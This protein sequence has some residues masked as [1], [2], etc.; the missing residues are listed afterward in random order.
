MPSKSLNHLSEKDLVNLIAYLKT[1]PAIDNTKGGNVLPAFTKILMQ[2]GAFGEVFSSEVIDHKAPF[3]EA[4]IASNN[5]EYGEY[6]V[7]V[8]DCSTCHGPDHVG[9]KS[10]DPNSPMVPNITS[11]GNLGKWSHE[12]FISTFRTGVT[13]E[14]KKMDNKFMPWMHIGQFSDS[15]LTAIH[16]YLKSLKGTPSKS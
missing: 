4:P 14:N 13:P 16:N 11:S 10:P 6:L 12:Q 7:N 9:G 8:I 1:I 2:L 15:D 5:K 3:K